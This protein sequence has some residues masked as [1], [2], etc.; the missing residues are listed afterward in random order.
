MLHTISKY[1]ILHCMYLFITVYL[2]NGYDGAM[3]NMT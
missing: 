1:I 2:Y 3:E